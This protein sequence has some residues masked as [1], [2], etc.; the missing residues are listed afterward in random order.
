MAVKGFE[1]NTI[2]LEITVEPDVFKRSLQAAQRKTR[3][4][5]SRF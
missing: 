5:C 2:T 4:A 1:E 3:A